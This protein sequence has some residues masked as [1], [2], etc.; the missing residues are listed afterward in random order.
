M[1][2][3]HWVAGDVPLS[4]NIQVMVC[5]AGGGLLRTAFES[6]RAVRLLEPTPPPG[7]WQPGPK[8][9][10]QK[11]E[12]MQLRA[13]LRLCELCNASDQ[14]ESSLRNHQQGRSSNGVKLR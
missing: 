5:V 8:A 10:R 13:H 9:V 2:H 12:R 1:C 14:C 11:G 4:E 6:E 3:A 7:V